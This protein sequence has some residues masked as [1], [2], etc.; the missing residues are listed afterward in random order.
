MSWNCNT[1][2]LIMVKPKHIALL[3]L[4]A[5]VCGSADAQYRR[6]KKRLFRYDGNL[7]NSGWHFAPGL[8]YTFEEFLQEDPVFTMGQ[9]SALFVQNEQAG[10]LGLAAEFGYFHLLRYGLVF[11]YLDYGVS[12]KQYKGR[13]TYTAELRDMLTDEV[14]SSTSGEGIFREQVVAFN[15]NLNNILQLQDY[16]F[17]TNS[18]G[19]HVDYRFRSNST[20][21]PVNTIVPQQRPA[22]LRGG[23]HYKLGYGYKIYDHLLMQF[24]LETPILSVYPWDGG[25]SSLA[26][27]SSRYRPVIFTVRFMIVRRPRGAD[28]PPVYKSPFDPVE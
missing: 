4:L 3:L 12:Y 13:E 10:V 27:F 1:F 2:N 9:D 11:H 28:C 6:K 15:F 14:F 19:F 26:W 22:Y 23:L 8:T 21:S 16:S 20:W 7:K 5:L 25:H 24:M 18:I 17:L